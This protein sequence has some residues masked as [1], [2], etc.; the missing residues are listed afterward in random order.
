[1]NTH[2]VSHRRVWTCVS[3]AGLL[4]SA[5]S[6][7]HASTYQAEVLADNPLIYYRLGESGG[8]TATNL[9]THGASGNG[10]Y[11]NFA[12]AAFGQTGIPG[13]GGDT[14]V[15]FDGANDW[16]S[17]TFDVVSTGDSTV[18]LEA[19]VKLTADV[20]TNGYAVSY[21]RDNQNNRY[22]AI[23]VN[24]SEQP[25]LSQDQAGG[26]GTA[27]GSSALV[28][29]EWYHLVAVFDASPSPDKLYVN[30]TLAASI[31]GPNPDSATRRFY[32]GLLHNRSGGTGWFKGI[33]DEV[34][35][36]NYQLPESRILAH[37]NVGI[38]EPAS[39]AGLGISTTLL[40][41]RRR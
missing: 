23:G 15:Q 35:F 36:Y 40:L 38:P 20:T 32:V 7:S 24:S 39:L 22:H 17:S 1:M 28:S 2:I 10:T 33:I 25:I 14:A 18:T 5:T 34:A 29:G 3:S 37:Y 21:L 41:R 19:W 27:T 26:G 9:G 16:I 30:G 12:A 4:A 31:N 11:T 13:G 6:Y 8:S